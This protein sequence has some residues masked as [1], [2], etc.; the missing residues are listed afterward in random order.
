MSGFPMF[1]FSNVPS[2]TGPFEINLQKVWISNGQISDLHSTVK[3]SMLPY[4]PNFGLLF[5]NLYLTFAI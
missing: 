5:L 4:G 3:W 1:R 2:K